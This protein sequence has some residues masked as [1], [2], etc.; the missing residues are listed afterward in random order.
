MHKT[1]QPVTHHACRSYAS[2][3]RHDHRSALRQPTRRP[4]SRTRKPAIITAAGANQ[5]PLV[6]VGSV[7]ADMMLQVDRFPKP[8]ETLSAKAMTTSAGGKGANQA[9]AAA[10]LGYPTYF[11]GQVGTDANSQL[12]KDSLTKCGVDLSY[13]REIEGPSGTAMIMVDPSGENII[14]IV[15]G[16]N[17]SKWKFSESDHK[18][19]SSAGVTV[20]LDCGG[21][22][23]DVDPELL[24]HL[25]IIS[26]NESELANLTDMPTESKEQVEA[27]A[28]SVQGKGVDIVLAKLGTKGSMLIQKDKILNQGILKADKVVDTTGAGDC[29]TGAVAVGILEGMSYQEAMKFAAAAS[30]LCVGKPGAMPSLPDRASVDG[31]LK[32]Q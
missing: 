10:S 5:K 31:L 13:L 27:A 26:P 7:N 18:L 17:Q 25:T 21:A 15:G 3:H 19:G 30:S 9:A 11:L 12:L 22:D 24:K 23:A 32:Q 14:M 28:R 1:Q 20:V 4:G 8:G 16:A 2:L 6:V 29:F